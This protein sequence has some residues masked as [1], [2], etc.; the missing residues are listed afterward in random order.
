M[1]VWLG[2]L[3]L[4][5]GA[6]AW[7]TVMPGRSHSG[8]LPPL[9]AEGQEI[10]HRLERHVRRLG[11]EIGERHALRPEALQ[12]AAAYLEE[13]LRALG[14]EPA[15][16][17]FTAERVAV[18]NLE[19]E[20]PG[21]SGDIVL[22]GAHYDSVLGASG[23]DDNASGVAALLELARALGREPRG[24]TLRFVFFVNEEPPW[25][26]TEA[27]G[28]V[29]YARRARQRGERI[30][31]MLSLETLGYYSDADGSQLYP[32]PLGWLY[33]SRG[34]FVGFVGNLGSRALVR[35][36]IAAFRRSAAFP[37]EGVAAPALI[38]GIG[39]SDHSSFW[40][41]GYPGVMA[42][43]TA[44]Y[45]YPAYHTLED[46]PEKIDHERLARVVVG[47]VGVVRSL[48]DE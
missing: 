32:W 15:A 18:R 22:V 23:A 14:L 44:L 43:D 28:S 45:R 24:R 8:P 26:M 25:F 4:I 33:P 38:P 7:M 19:A 13:E 34:D 35:R 3:L 21:R 41:Q 42:T 10:R 47:L 1:A 30:A 6:V 36:A 9:G 46:T 39:W 5:V 27:M 48:A 16:Q 17:E 29:R 12:A 11:G 20:V 31:A 2:L 37:S 40:Q